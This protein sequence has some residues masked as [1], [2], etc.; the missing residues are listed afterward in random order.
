MNCFTHYITFTAVPAHKA[1]TGYPMEPIKGVTTDSMKDETNSH[2]PT[3]QEAAI[4]TPPAPITADDL[5]AFFGFE[6]PVHATKVTPKASEKKSKKVVST[7][8]MF[9]FLLQKDK[10]SSF[11]NDD[12]DEPTLNGVNPLVMKVADDND[13]SSDEDRSKRGK[14]VFANNT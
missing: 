6:Q 9:N 10:L 5:D 14:N 4:L 3:E 2:S 1:A 12:D 11:Y 7:Y 8:N 13:S